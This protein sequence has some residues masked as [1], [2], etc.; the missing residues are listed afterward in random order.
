MTKGSKGSGNYASKAVAT[1]GYAS[2]VPVKTTV[3]FKGSGGEKGSYQN[4]SQYSYGDK[5][6]G[7]YGRATTTE[8]ASAG[9]FHWKNGTTGTRSEYTQSSTFRFGDKRGYTEVRNEQSFRNVSYNKSNSGSYITY[10]DDDEDGGSDG[11]YDD[12]DDDGGSYYDSESDDCCDSDGRGSD[13]GYDSDGGG[14]DG[15]C[16]SDDSGSDGG[17][18][19]EY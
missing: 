5:Q 1:T 15:G 9:D 3:S 12:D 8:K 16:D 11:G 13:G 17:Y 19:S 4:K 18:D 14:T 10:G 7:S 2:S 6:T